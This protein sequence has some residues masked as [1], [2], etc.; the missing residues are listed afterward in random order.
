MTFP[1]GAAIAD[2]KGLFNAGLDGSPRRAID[3]REGDEIDA[4][5]LT[6]LLR[7]AI[8]FNR[9]KAK[10]SAKADETHASYA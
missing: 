4:D 6:T 8:A 3:L 7:A 9:D 2:P 1:H 5:A 10:R